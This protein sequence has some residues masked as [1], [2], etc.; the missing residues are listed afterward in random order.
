MNNNC[1]NC[2]ND[3]RGE[4]CASKVPI[5]ENLDCDEL[6]EIVKSI[7]HNRYSKGEVLFSEGS[8]ANSMFF[9]NEGKVKLYKYTKEGKE[10]ILHILSEGEF[11]GEL[12]LV[13]SSIHNFN[14][15]AIKN[16]KI[17]SLSNEEMKNII[18][19]NPQIGIK[20][21]QS[22]GERLDSIENLAQNLATNDAD[23]RV[24]YLLIDLLEKSGNINSDKKEINIQMS[25]EDMAN[26]VGVTRETLSRKLR[27][28]E[29]EGL[30]KIVK[31]KQI[32]IL[33]EEGLRDYI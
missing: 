1:T 21:L 24:A 2:C 13:N 32:L 14:A 30:I 6:S 28:F 11:F 29:D 23:S 15:Q 20:L 7:N 12:N 22:V 3:C 27:S 16:C 25:R 33:D 18:M 8:I 31:I 19:K 26:C 4:Y 5:F 9:V 10:Q 17:C